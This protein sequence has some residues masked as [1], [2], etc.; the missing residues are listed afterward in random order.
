MSGLMLSALALAL[1]V[2]GSGESPSRQ[3]PG[4]RPAQDAA[5]PLPAT[6]PREPALNVVRLGVPQ[7]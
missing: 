2:E 7:R 4:L 5:R 6:P 1:G 3:S